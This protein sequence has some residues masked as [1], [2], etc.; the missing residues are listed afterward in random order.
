MAELFGDLEP[1]R[2]EY[3]NRDARLQVMD[4][5]GIESVWLFPTLGVGI[6]EALVHDPGAAMAAFTSFNRWLSPPDKVLMGWPSLR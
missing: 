3:R 5:Q 4:E 2:P 1:I 6:E